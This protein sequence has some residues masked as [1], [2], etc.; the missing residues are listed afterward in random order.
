MIT[1][2]GNDSAPKF[3]LYDADQNNNRTQSN[4]SNSKR[5]NNDSIFSFHYFKMSACKSPQIILIPSG[6]TLRNPLKFRRSQDFYIVSLIELN[7][8]DS[9]SI[10]TQWIPYIETT[11]SELFIRFGL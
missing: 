1:V 11:S 9:T 4:L 2:A 3:D 6:S 7:C 5:E 10:Q 8:N